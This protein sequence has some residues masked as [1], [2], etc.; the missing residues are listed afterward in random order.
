MFLSSVPSTSDS[1][2]I[3][4]FEQGE[5]KF[6]RKT[7]KDTMTGCRAS[8]EEINQVL[9]LLEIV[10]SNNLTILST[11][12]SFLLRMLVFFAL[13]LFVESFWR[14]D[15]MG[16]PS[17]ICFWYGIGSLI[18]LWRKQSSQSK[19]TKRQAEKVIAEV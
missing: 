1:T 4:P 8:S 3:I 14:C 11:A 5:K 15:R 17:I 18:Y 6:S 7:Y 19:E 16:G 10:A 13:A 9:T 12:L 2:I